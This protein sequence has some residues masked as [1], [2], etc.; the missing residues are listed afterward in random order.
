MSS[1]IV[2]EEKNTEN[3]QGS[4]RIRLSDTVLKWFNFIDKINIL[5]DMEK[6]FIIRFADGPDKFKHILELKNTSQH[7]GKLKKQRF[8]LKK[9]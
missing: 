5:N 6:E 1:S 9:L 2:A 4:I 8:I 7:K 3:G